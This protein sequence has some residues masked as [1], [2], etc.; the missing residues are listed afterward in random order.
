MTK[1]AQ[2]AAEQLMRDVEKH[3]ADQAVL[4]ETLE[5]QRARAAAEAKAWLAIFQAILELACAGAG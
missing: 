1:R 2:V 4:T 3:A 5:L